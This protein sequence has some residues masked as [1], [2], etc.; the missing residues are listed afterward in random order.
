MTLQSSASPNLPRG[1]G[2]P[3]GP[4]D[5]S[6]AGGLGPGRWID[7]MG[8][9]VSRDW[10]RSQHGDRDFRSSYL[11]ELSYASEALAGFFPIHARANGDTNPLYNEA[12]IL[13]KPSQVQVL[14]GSRTGYDNRLLIH[15]CLDPAQ[16]RDLLVR[17]I[18]RAFAELAAP[19]LGFWYLPPNEADEVCALPGLSTT[20]ARCLP[21]AV[22]DV[23]GLD[24]LEDYLARLP[25]ARRSLVR[26]DLRRIERRGYRCRSVLADRLRLA[27][28]APLVVQVQRRRGEQLEEVGAI[29]YLQRCLTGDL[30]DRAIIHEVRDPSGRLAA[31]SLGIR[32]GR[33]FYLRV[34]GADYSAGHGRSGEY[35]QA[36]VYGPV[37]YAMTHGLRYVHLGVTSYRAK[38]LR[39]ARLHPREVV[40]VARTPAELPRVCVDWAF[41]GDDARF[42]EQRQPELIG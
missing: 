28:Y 32:H 34:F 40:I 22:L 20:R 18:N 39:G 12:T 42:I 13:A 7:E 36:T 5:D 2:P 6:F 1:D 27:D 41:L 38:C 15:P 23:G 8:F 14:V 10:T 4:G 35:F 31:F 3:T 25:G 29:R 16:R 11:A 24:S 37:C 17:V 9:Y 33:G 21:S 26:R 30:L 19:H